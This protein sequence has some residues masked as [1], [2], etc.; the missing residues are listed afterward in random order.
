MARAQRVADLQPI[1]AAHWLKA[2]AIMLAHALRACHLALGA[3]TWLGPRRNSKL[4][5]RYDQIN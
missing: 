4:L 5:L 3:G 1:E 2:P